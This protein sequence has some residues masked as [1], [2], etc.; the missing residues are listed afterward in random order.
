MVGTTLKTMLLRMK[1][2]PLVPLSMT[3]FSAPVCRDRWKLKS[4]LCRCS[5]TLLA[6]SLMAPCVICSSIAVRAW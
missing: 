2:M 3:L 5:N 4:R 6:A 1:L